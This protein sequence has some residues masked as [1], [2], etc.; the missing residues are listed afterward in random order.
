[1]ERQPFG[2]RISYEEGGKTDWGNIPIRYA[3]WIPQESECFRGCVID[4]K[5]S[6]VCGIIGVRDGDKLAFMLVTDDQFDS[7]NAIF[8]LD[9]KGKTGRFRGIALAFP[10][11]EIEL[12]RKARFELLEEK[13][14]SRLPSSEDAESFWNRIQLLWPEEKLIQALR[15]CLNSGGRIFYP[16]C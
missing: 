16:P 11:R 8:A 14:N 15:D 9:S 1:M 12:I 2:I 13:S 10:D 5:T 7:G 4:T 3:G 6:K